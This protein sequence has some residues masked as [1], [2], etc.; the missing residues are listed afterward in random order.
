[1]FAKGETCAEEAG[2]DRVQGKFEQF[3]DFTVGELFKFAKEQDFAI[4]GVKTAEGLAEPQNFVV[5]VSSNG[6]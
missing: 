4:D 3:P 1:M 2:A 6:G 5:V